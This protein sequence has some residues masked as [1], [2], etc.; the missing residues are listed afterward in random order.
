MA[1]FHYVIIVFLITFWGC[2]FAT[3]VRDISHQLDRIE[4]AVTTPVGTQ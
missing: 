4:H 3:S 1:T 2:I